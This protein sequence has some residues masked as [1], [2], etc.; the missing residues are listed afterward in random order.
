MGTRNLTCVYLNKKPVV[1][2][3]CQWDGYPTGQGQTILEFLHNTYQPEKFQDQLQKIVEITNDQIA[4]LIGVEK[5]ALGVPYEQY[6]QFAEKYPHLARNMGGDVLEFIQTTQLNQIP[7]K[8]SIDFAGDGLF[9]EWCYVIDL[10]KNTFEV[11]TGFK[12]GK[13]GKTQRFYKY[14]DAGN[15]YT[16]VKKVASW[17][18][19]SLPTLEEFYSKLGKGK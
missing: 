15:E 10:D 18:L 17:S 7:L 8:N 5:G 16:P 2:K 6:Q 12:K 1:A 9:C 13:F 14:Y 11:Y 19:N 4:E 3:Y